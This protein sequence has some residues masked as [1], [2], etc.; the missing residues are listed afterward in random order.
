MNRKLSKD[1]LLYECLGGKCSRSGTDEVKYELT[2]KS[3]I[4]VRAHPNQCLAVGKYLAA[5][6]ACNVIYGYK[7]LDAGKGIVMSSS[8]AALSR[9][10]HSSRTL[11]DAHAYMH[12]HTLASQLQ[13]ARAVPIPARQ[14]VR[15]RCWWPVTQ[16]ARQLYDDVPNQSLASSGQLEERSRS[17]VD[18]AEWVEFGPC[19]R[20]H[21]VGERQ[22][23]LA[24]QG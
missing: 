3:W 15:R 13:V 1:L 24:S 4:H 5:T 2:A 12:V 19:W 22:S 7:P 21:R 23:R 16:P 20:R 10:A 9:L 17:V 18:E 14:G 11:T 8:F 6:P